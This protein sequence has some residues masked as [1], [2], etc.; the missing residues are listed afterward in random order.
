MIS[1][2]DKLLDNCCPDGISWDGFMLNCEEAINNPEVHSDEIST[3]DEDLAQEERDTNK[4]PENILNTSSVIKIY[5]KKWRSTRV[6]KVA[7]L[8]F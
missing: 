8:F 3:D 4:R 2:R 7:R 1:T 5:E 6:C